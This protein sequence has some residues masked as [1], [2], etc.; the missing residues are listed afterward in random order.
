MKQNKTR[1][2]QRMSRGTGLIRLIGLAL[3]AVLVLLL[4]CTVLSDDPPKE[5]D[6]AARFAAQERYYEVID[7][8]GD[9]EGAVD[10]ARIVFEREVTNH[11]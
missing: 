3:C 2:E 4:W 8:Y 1:Y 9:M 10:A 6:R 7:L 11:E 5:A